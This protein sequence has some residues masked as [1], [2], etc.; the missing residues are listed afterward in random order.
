MLETGQHMSDKLFSADYLQY[1]SSKS[2]MVNAA[3]PIEKK[4]YST[5]ENSSLMSSDEGDITS[6]EDDDDNERNDDSDT[7]N[8][9]SCV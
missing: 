4:F 3:R 2:L 8:N 1:P 7:G 5:N 9:D 6:Y